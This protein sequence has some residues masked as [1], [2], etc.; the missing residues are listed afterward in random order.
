M[1]NTSKYEKYR[2]KKFL[3]QNFLTDVNISKKIISFLEIEEGDTVL[4]IGPGH[5]ALTKL[6]LNYD[7]NL[8]AIEID[9]FAFEEL[10]LNL[11]G[12]VKIIHQD[13]LKTKLSDFYNGKK[14][15]V[16]GNIPYNITSQILFKLF[17]NYKIISKAVLMMQKEV[18]HRLKSV[19]NTK[20]YGILSVF[21]N[22]YS[23]PKIVYNVPPGAFFPKPKVDSSVVSM[24]FKDDIVVLKNPE[25]FRE[26]VRTSFN[27]RR[28]TLRNSLRKLFDE[29]NIDVN[30]IKF[31]LSKRPEMLNIIE[32]TELTDEIFSGLRID[33]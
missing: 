29:K 6:L 13:F 4:E 31:D 10:S 23:S 26:V 24:D 28:K 1:K 15:K 7:I 11:E 12:K 16:I 17:E 20:E 5:G 9:K 18:A 14:I 19:P 21:T 2:P 25:L 30:A 22:L 33:N 27:Q 8:T 32:F 3:G